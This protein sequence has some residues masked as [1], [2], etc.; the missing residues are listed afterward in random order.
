MTLEDEARERMKRDGIIPEKYYV[1]QHNHITPNHERTTTCPTCGWTGEHDEYTTRENAENGIRKK[2][3]RT[4]FINTVAEQQQED[5]KRELIQ[6]LARGNWI[7]KGAE[8][9]T[10]E[11]PIYYDRTGAWWVWNPVLCVWEERDETDILN[12]CRYQL[13]LLGDTSI[14]HGKKLVDGLK[15]IARERNP[16][17]P[18]LHLVQ[19]GTTFYNIKTGETKKSTPEYF[20][21]NTIPW[22]VG[23]ISDTPVMDALITSWVGEEH[24]Q[25][26]YELLAYCTYRGYPIHR[27]FCF[28]GSGANGKTRFIKIIEKF[29]GDTNKSSVSLKKLIGNNFAIYPLYRKLVCFVGE[30]THH[31]LE[32]TD[33]LK[34]LSGEDPVDFEAKGRTGFTGTSYAKLIVGTN[35]LPPSV[36]T[37]VGWYRRWFIVQ[38]PNEFQEGEDVLKRIP[39]AEY[40]ALARKCVVLL[41][42]VLAR[43]SFS[44]EGTW[45]QRQEKYV[46]QSNPIK[47]FLEEGYLRDMDA[48]IPYSECYLEYLSFLSRKRLRRVSKKDFTSSLEDEGLETQRKSVRDGDSIL[49]IYVIV[50]LRKRLE[51]SGKTE[52]NV[53]VVGGVVPTLKFPPY[54]NFEVLSDSGLLPTCT[55]PPTLGENT[56]IVAEKQENDTEKNVLFH[57]QQNGLSLELFKEWIKTEPSRLKPLSEIE[58]NWPIFYA[59]LNALKQRGELYEPKPGMIGVLE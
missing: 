40:S 55:T 52:R 53:G 9:L 51:N 11:N 38:F 18:P 37:S 7:I 16:K 30:T 58:K 44:S 54:R 20:S 49:S 21:T 3:E 27:I 23:E 24:L 45:E 10:R 6:H 22:E 46:E 50:G 17:E 57:S 2:N 32:S 39:D 34:A 42:Q 1:C 43:G 13:E 25:T 28:V 59:H 35:V 4:T 36:D 5:A 47:I 29:V 48:N 15:Q 8:T 33:I 19:F 26:M 14:K 31:K 41:P 56:E 12:L